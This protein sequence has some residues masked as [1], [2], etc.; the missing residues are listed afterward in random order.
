MKRLVGVLALAMLVPLPAMAL[1][2]FGVR[3]GV[4]VGL[5][6]D[7]AGGDDAEDITAFAIGGA[8]KLDLPLLDVEVDLLYTR[9]SSTDSE[10]DKDAANTYL[11][12]PVLA[13]VGIPLVPLLSVGAGLEMRYWLGATV[14]GD[15]VDGADDFYESTVFYLPLLLAVDLDLS[16]IQLSVDARYEFQITNFAKIGDDLVL[17]NPPFYPAKKDDAR[18]HEFMLF[19]GAFF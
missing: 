13:R 1:G 3:L 4:G 15:D 19:A 6:N 18:I 7:D 11:S 16:V 9:L 14:D 10:T 17:A 12:I 2:N 8:W 5:P